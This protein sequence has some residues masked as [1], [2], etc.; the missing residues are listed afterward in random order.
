M[1]SR[2]DDFLALHITQTD[3]IH[4]VGHFLP[5]HRYYLWLFEQAL[6]DECGYA[7]ALPYWDWTLDAVPDDNTTFASSPVFYAEGGFGGNGPW[8]A[9]LSDFPADAI[10]IIAVPGRSGGGCITDGPFADYQ[11]SMGPGNHTEYTPHCI[12]RDFSPW[13]AGF[14]VSRARYD[15]VQAAPD[16]WELT[17]RVESV[18][19]EIPDISLHGGGHLSVGGEAGEVSAGGT[20]LP[21]GAEWVSKEKPGRLTTAAAVIDVQHV[22][23]PGRPPLLVAPRRHR[24][25]VG[26]VAATGYDV[27]PSLH[28]VRFR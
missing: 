22:F 26:R 14:S 23:E 10:S 7:A 20:E 6:R 13:L 21:E 11:I 17:H 15:E 27:V 5:W 1:R 8:I 12:R 18:S 3:Y 25:H 4:W 24:P 9:D 16:Y 19:L 28:R 2:Y